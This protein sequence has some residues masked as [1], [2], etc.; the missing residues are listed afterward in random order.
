MKNVALLKILG[1][2]LQCLLSKA[3]D[4]ES[5]GGMQGGFFPFFP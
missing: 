1:S 3:K 4:K 2:D 5:L